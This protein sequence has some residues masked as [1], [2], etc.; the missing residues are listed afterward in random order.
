MMAVIKWLL[1]F[2]LGGLFLTSGGLK[3][4]DPQAFGKAILNYRLVGESLA[5]LS[6]LWIPWMEVTGALGLFFAKWR[7]S[8]LWLLGILIV[9]FEVILLI[10]LFRGLD[11]DCGC[12][13]TKSATSVSFALMRNIIILGGLV[14]VGQVEGSQSR[15]K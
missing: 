3:L 11:I 13:G 5:W 10:T 15:I 14:L 4:M 9:V 6:A 8:A 7:R 1:I 2:L 12:F